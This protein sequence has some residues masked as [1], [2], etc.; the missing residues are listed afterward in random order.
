MII[1]SLD[2]RRCRRIHL[3][4]Y[5]VVGSA[6][7]F[8]AIRCGQCSLSF[9]RPAQRFAAA[10]SEERLLILGISL[11]AAPFGRAQ[12]RTRRLCELIL[13][14]IPASRPLPLDSFSLDL[15]H[16]L[17]RLPKQML[18]VA[19]DG[20]RTRHVAILDCHAEVPLFHHPILSSFEVG[21][22]STFD[23]NSI[24]ELRSHATVYH[25][26]VGVVIHVHGV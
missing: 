6:A 26:L 18:L 8:R 15:L 16:L 20:P 19:P 11:E 25:R 13:P 2:C 4:V 23:P 9:R 10:T 3:T 22:G 5:L 1:E 7:A 17:H 14:K 21:A 12:L 24:V